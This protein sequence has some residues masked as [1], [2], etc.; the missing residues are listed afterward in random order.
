MNLVRCFLAIWTFRRIESI[1]WMNHEKIFQQ[2]K[3]ETKYHNTQNAQKIKSI[4]SSLKGRVIIVQKVKIIIKKRQ[5]DIKLITVCK[6]WLI[7]VFKWFGILFTIS[8]L[9]LCFTLDV[10]ISLGV[11]SSQSVWSYFFFSPSLQLLCH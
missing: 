11:W 8:S 3:N 2:R 5:N 10:N 6:M 9:K 1:R 7:T 4:P